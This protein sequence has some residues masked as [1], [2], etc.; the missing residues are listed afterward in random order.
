MSYKKKCVIIITLV[1]ILVI[2]TVIFLLFH[3]NNKNSEKV[4][5]E[6]FENGWET[7]IVKEILEDE[8]PVPVGYTYIEGN[9]QNGVVIQDDVTKNEYMWIPYEDVYEE[10]VDLLGEVKN[11]YSG[12]LYEN[13]SATSINEIDKY[14]GFYVMLENRDEDILYEEYKDNFIKKCSETLTKEEIYNIKEELDLMSY[15]Q[16]K[17]CYETRSGTSLELSDINNISDENYEILNILN[18]N[19]YNKNKNVR[20]KTLTSEEL[21]CIKAYENKNNIN[22]DISNS[23]RTFTL[24]ES[25]VANL[26]SEQT[27]GNVISNEIELSNGKKASIPNGFELEEYIKNGSEENISIKIKNG[28]NL[29]FVWIPVDNIEE[30]ENATAT[31]DELREESSES[32]ITKTQ[33]DTSKDTEEYKKMIESIEKYGGYYVSEAELS[34]DNSGYVANKFRNMGNLGTD[35]EGNILYG[36]ENGEYYRNGNIKTDALFANCNINNYDK[37]K[38]V[39]D[40]LYSTSTTVTS[41]VM[42]AN[43][44]DYMLKWIMDTNSEEIKEQM[45]NDS[46][47][48]GKYQVKKDEEGN[49]LTAGLWDT[50][51]INGFFGLGGNLWEVTQ[52]NLDNMIA[53]R[54]GCYASRGNENPITYKRWVNSSDWSYEVAGDQ[55]EQTGQ[56]GMRVSFYIKT[57][58]EENEELKSAKE[59]AKEEFDKIYEQVKTEYEETTALKSVKEYIHQKIDEQTSTVLLDKLV[60]YGKITLQ[61]NYCKAIDMLKENTENEEA[62]EMLNTIKNTNFVGEDGTLVNYVE[63]AETVVTSRDDVPIPEGFYY[64]TGD[65]ETGLVI[66]DNKGDENNSNSNLGNQFVWIPVENWEDMAT[67]DETSKNY[68]AKLYNFANWTSNGTYEFSK[69]LID[70]SKTPWSE[71]S[72]GYREPAFLNLN[73]NADN[74]TD[75]NGSKRVNENVGLGEDITNMQNE[76]NEMME[77]VKKNKGFYI[78]RYETTIHPE[79]N[80]SIG[81]KANSTVYNNVNWYWAYKTGKEWI[82][83]DSVQTHLIWG[84]QWD[85]ALDFI[86]KSDSNY[87]I[88]STNAGYYGQSIDSQPAKSGSSTDFARNNI[89]DMAGNIWEWTMEAY[90]EVFRVYRGGSYTGRGSFYPANYRANNFAPTTESEQLGY[91]ISM[92]LK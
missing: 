37:V 80:N 52:E 67:Y 22:V 86:S 10:A 68:T 38:E 35:E 47:D 91:R 24:L 27:E 92:Y 75:A 81:S 66:S 69:Q 21:A 71:V 72:I 11:A 16:Y 74:S 62:Q 73:N 29:S 15:E 5:S 39:A 41:H 43:E 7:S 3:R 8:I 77:S 30:F 4:I 26:G 1:A 51:L 13:M 28:D 19:D 76:Y 18:S 48:I 64:V 23:L 79:A 17:E 87:V 33:E 65:K 49:D 70:G 40:A 63:M 59:K 58:Y 54:G 55:V 12:R 25:N 89:Y 14:N 6:H 31:I 32:E 50:T 36:I 45:L 56:I 46:S 88:N 82:S 85:M 2:C 78:A 60:N 53:L 9:K 61:D 44:H 84:S 90:T 83:N 42:Y 57:E 20:T 34:I